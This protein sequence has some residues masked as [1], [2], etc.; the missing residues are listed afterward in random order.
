MKCEFIKMGINGE[1]IGY[2]DKLPVFCDDV[3]PQEVAIIKIQKQ[4]DTYAKAKLVKRLKDH[5]DRIRPRCKYQQTCGGCPIMTL[6]YP[7]QLQYKME[8]L[9]QT[10]LKYGNV[11][12]HFIRPMK[13]SE[14][15]FFYRN[16]CKF[17]FGSEK[18]KL[19]M[20]MYQTG[21]NH[22]VPIKECV[23][24]DEQ[25]E[26][27]RIQILKIL[28]EDGYQAYQNKTKSGLRYLVLRTLQGKTH[29]AL[30][31]GKDTIQ[32][33]TISKIMEITGMESLSQSI[34]TKQN[35]PL[36]FGKTTLLA[37]TPHIQL[38]IGN[39]TLNLAITSFFQMN[40]EQA[41]SMYNMVVSKIDPC[42]TLVEAYC[43]IGT[44]SLLAHQKAK[45][46]F[47]I[48]LIESAVKNA[49]ENANQNGIHNAKFICDD[50]ANGLQKILVR[51]PVDTLLVDP[52]RTGLDDRMI[53]T[54]LTSQIKKIIYVSCNPSTLAKNLKQLKRQYQVKTIIPFDL[55]PQTP[56]IETITVL[57]RG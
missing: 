55:F 47:G 11:K 56:H 41:T 48:E 31:T 54:I 18:G 57:E 13:A 45:Q 44:M 34:N 43:G 16:E 42:D 32:P 20:G 19:V 17:P 22:L 52:S 24:Q 1:G 9:Q 29:G 27:T 50:A 30:V 3:L 39:L 40:L 4:T 49:N 23:I 36:I 10:L 26:K 15:T 37:G 35:T 7:T 51:Q 6:K 53:Q 38:T 28:Q 33:N 21:T 2:I 5:P 14:K 46:I 25:L 12:A 8:I